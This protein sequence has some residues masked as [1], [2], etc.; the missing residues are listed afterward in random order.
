MR[1][2]DF[3]AVRK[4]IP[5]GTVLDLSRFAPS[6]RKGRQLRGPCPIHRSEFD[7][8]RSFSVNLETNAFRCFSCGAKGNQLD[9][10][11][12]ATGQSLFHA[13]IDLC[14]RAGIEVPRLPGRS[15][16]RVAFRTE[17]RNP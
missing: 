11:A 14:R 16:E 7:M 5:I 10:W 15:E 12:L 4:Q 1:S 2:V 9:L 17:K 6:E 3:S 13:A 8:S